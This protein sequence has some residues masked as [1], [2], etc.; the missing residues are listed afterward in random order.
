MKANY[1]NHLNAATAEDHGRPLVRYAGVALIDVRGDFPSVQVGR[2]MAQRDAALVRFVSQHHDAAFYADDPLEGDDFP[3]EMQRLQV[4]H[5]VHRANGW[6]G[7]GYHT[8]GFPS[9]RLYLVGSFDTQR[10]N[11]AGRNH[12]SI[13]HCTAGLWQQTP[14]PIGSQLVAALAS[15]AA[16][17][18]AGRMLPVISHHDAARASDPTECCGATRDQWVP[19]LPLAI[20]AIARTLHGTV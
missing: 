11:V 20:E 13:G 10:A 15:I 18:Y 9:G 7:I 3:A 4:V 14:P 2:T 12:K 16:W 1:A 8:Y 17:S 6:G 19:R 5:E